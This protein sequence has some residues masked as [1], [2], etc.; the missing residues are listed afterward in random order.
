LRFDQVDAIVTACKASA[1]P[2]RNTA[3]VWLLLESGLRRFE[4]AALDVC[5]VDLRKRTVVVRCGKFGKARVAVMGD[6]AAQALWRYLKGRRDKEGALFLSKY[7]GRL[8]AGGVSQ[9]IAELGRK[10]GLHLHPH[11]FRHSWAHYAMSAGVSET[12]LMQ[13][14]GWETRTML[15]RYGAELK[16]ERVIAAMRGLQVSQVMRGT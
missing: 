16:Q 14:A 8:T 7:G 1:D 15:D 2:L 11:A 3:M 12:N 9:I 13:V 5:D 10:A 4:L 6:E